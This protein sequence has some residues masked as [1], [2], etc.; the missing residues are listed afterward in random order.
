MDQRYDKQYL[1]N[2]FNGWHQEKIRVCERKD[3]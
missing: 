1:K 2:T 3:Q